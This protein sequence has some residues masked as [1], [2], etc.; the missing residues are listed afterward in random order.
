MIQD[1][2]KRF[3][4]STGIS[5]DTRKIEP[6]NIFFA[7]KGPNFNANKFAQKALSE[8][9]SLSVVDEKEFAISPN[10]LLVKNVLHTLQDLA[11]Y[12]RHQ[13]KIPVIGITGSNGKTTT[14]EL[15][16]AVLSEKYKCQAT[17]GNL[18]NHIGVP[19]T[20]L[21]LQQDTEIAIIEMGANKLGD[22]NELCRIAEPTQ[23][24]ITNIGKAHTEGFGSFEGVLRG[25]SELYHWLIQNNGTVFINS[26]DAILMNMSKRFEKPI[27]YPGPGDY[28]HCNLIEANP[29]V[30]I[31][32]EE[33]KII[34]TQLIG[35]YNY[36][37]I[38]AAL[39]IGKYFEVNSGKASSAVAQYIPTNNRSQILFIGTNTII[40]DAYNANPDSMS[41]A[42][43]NL[44]GMEGKNKVLILGDMFELGDLTEVEHR[45]IGELTLKESFD[46]V[47]FCGERM[48]YA[49]QGNRNSR[50]FKSR[51][52]LENYIE[53]CIFE[54][55][56]IL[57]KGSR[58]MALEVIAQK[59]RSS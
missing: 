18:N 44:S 12:H 39:C 16:R 43:Q 24:I 1:L 15:I 14:K 5:T 42:I 35:R 17:E 47:I 25:K 32:D 40:L 34:K 54:D 26:E 52:E 36:Q 51:T 9:A 38:A 33:K 50:Y 2:Y 49:H 48:Q 46:K 55:S 8:G 41:A 27:L 23:G 19:L 57:I 3:V 37:N 56:L 4:L 11:N 30:T 53:S 6:G 7:L 28:Y 10:T 20:I 31:E 58:G 45:R 22:I 13:L 21:S 29:W 59:I